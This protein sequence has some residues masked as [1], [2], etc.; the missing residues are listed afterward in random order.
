MFEFEWDNKKAES[1][2]LK[3]H[4]DF[5]DAVAVFFDDERLLEIDP[6][7]KE[8]RYRIIGMA[9]N[10]VLFVVYTERKDAYRIISARKA[11][12]NERKKYYENISQ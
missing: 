4:V 5:A 7:E 9:A 1:N 11:S 8:Q 10:G 6:Y 2:F 3:H 12:K